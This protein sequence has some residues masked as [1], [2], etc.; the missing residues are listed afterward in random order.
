MQTRLQ[1]EVAKR[2]TSHQQLP[3]S[4]TNSQNSCSHIAPQWEEL[5]PQYQVIDFEHFQIVM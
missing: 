3:R 4:Y 1:K 2:L 5:D